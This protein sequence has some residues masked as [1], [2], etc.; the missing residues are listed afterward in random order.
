MD[1]PHSHL[2][3]QTLDALAATYAV[4]LRPH[5]VPAPG[6]GFLGD[7]AR[8]PRWALADA[9]DIAPFHGL[10]PPVGEGDRA[11]IPAIAGRLASARRGR[12]RPSRWNSAG[13]TSPG[14]K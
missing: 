3:V 13:R 6:P 8:Q 14:K 5:L 12:P 9:R 10:E 11:S 2:A 4:E 7:E 1:D